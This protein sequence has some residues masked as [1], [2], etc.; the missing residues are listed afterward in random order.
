VRVFVK[1]DGLNA[2]EG[3]SFSTVFWR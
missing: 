2:G 3:V 1:L